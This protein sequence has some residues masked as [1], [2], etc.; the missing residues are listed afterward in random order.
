LSDEKNEEFFEIVFSL[1]DSYNTL[2][3]ELTRT[4]T[5]DYQHTEPD[6]TPGRIIEIT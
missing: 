4:T 5:D 2:V 3:W 6:G 1:N